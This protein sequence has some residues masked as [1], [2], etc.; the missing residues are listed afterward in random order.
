VELLG[1]LSRRKAFWT[2]CLHVGV[3]TLSLLARRLNTCLCSWLED[4]RCVEMT[5]WDIGTC[6][7][8]GGS[9][10]RSSQQDVDYSNFQL[11]VHWR[12]CRYRTCCILQLAAILEASFCWTLE[13]QILGN[14]LKGWL[15]SSS[16]SIAGRRTIWR[17]YIS[18]ICVVRISTSPKSDSGWTTNCSGTV[19]VLVKCSLVN[20]ILL[21]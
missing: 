4:A 11:C 1:L 18:H 7:G 8:R 3:H 16:I 20:D 13:L 19:M 10:R 6:V 14:H 15:I 17:E 5:H 21:Q 12:A 2:G 9:P